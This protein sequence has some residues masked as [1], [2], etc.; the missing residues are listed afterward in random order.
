MKST[1]GWRF[2]TAAGKEEILNPRIGH[3]NLKALKFADAYDEVQHLY[4]STDHTGDKVLK[5]KRK[6]SSQKDFTSQL[7]IGV[8]NRPVSLRPAVL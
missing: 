8:Q 2:D 7:S 6:P 1:D 5:I 3:N 4:A